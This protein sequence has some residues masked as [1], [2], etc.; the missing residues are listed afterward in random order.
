MSTANFHQSVRGVRSRRPLGFIGSPY[1]SGNYRSITGVNQAPQAAQV[2]TISVHGSPDSSTLYSVT[3][4]GVVASYTTDS[5]ATQAELGAGLVAAINATPGIRSKCVAS[6][7]GGTLTLTGVWPGVSFTASV[8]SADTTNDLGTPSTSTAAASASA[9]DF[10]R[11]LATDG[12]AADEGVQ[13]VFVP[14]TSSFSAQVISFTFAGSTASYYHGSV[15]VNGKRYMWGGVVWTSDLD[16]TCTAIA[17]AINAV[18]PAETVIAA[19]VGSGGGVVT[20]TAEVEGA[21]FEADAH[22][23]GH[24]DAEATKVYTTGPSVSTSLRRAFAGLSVRRED[25]E[26]VTAYGDDPAYPANGGVE[27]MVYGEMIVQRDTSETW[28]LGDEVYVS[29][30]SASAGRIYDTAGTDRVWLP[31]DLLVI[32]RSEH[33]TTSDGIGIVGIKGA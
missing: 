7:A 26:D 18:L 28:A 11:V 5:S 10:G 8:N 17:N 20:L 12:Y 23:Q 21:E 31:P 32:K 1:R 33:S 2:T 4:D 30:A 25:V 15:D 22:A 19:S 24:A 29:L 6:Y 3:V 9:V 13:K 16:T 27:S 14:T